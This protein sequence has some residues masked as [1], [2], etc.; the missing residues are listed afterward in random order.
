[1][2]TVPEP[3]GA[4]ADILVAEFTVKDVAAV[5]PNLTDV[6]PVKPVPVIVT[7]VPPDARP[8][9]GEIDAIV[10]ADEAPGS[11][12]EK[13]YGTVAGQGEPWLLSPQL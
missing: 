12:N 1:M 13:L 9:A 4:T 8:V 5:P 10:G 6:A 7:A 11:A 2:S 3:A